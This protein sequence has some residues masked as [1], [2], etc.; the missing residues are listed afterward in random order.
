MRGWVEQAD[1]KA[2]FAGLGSPSAEA[3]QGRASQG[4]VGLSRE[5]PQAHG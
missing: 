3:A 4:D 2:P 1:G 5:G